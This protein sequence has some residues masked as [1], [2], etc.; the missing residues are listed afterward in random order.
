MFWKEFGYP[1]RCALTLC[2]IWSTLQD[3]STVSFTV[4][5]IQP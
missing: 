1:V 4:C 3:A 2:R 5:F